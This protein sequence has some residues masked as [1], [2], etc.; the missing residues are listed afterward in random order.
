MN[1]ADNWTTKMVN[2]VDKINNLGKIPKLKTLEA[3]FQW[4][5]NQTPNSKLNKTTLS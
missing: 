1:Y 2:Q 5:R 4:E 3:Y